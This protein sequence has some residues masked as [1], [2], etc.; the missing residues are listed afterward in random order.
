MKN[1]SSILKVSA[2]ALFAM[3]MSVFA[4]ANATVIVDHSNGGVVDGNG[5][6]NMGGSNWT[7]WD[8]FTL[9]SGATINAIT[10]YAYNTWQSNSPY[11]LQIGTA[12]GLSDV[13]STAIAGSNVTKTLSGYTAKY[14]ASFAPVTLD[15]GTYWITFN[16]QDNLYGSAYAADG[17]LVQMGYGYVE[18]RNGNASVF[19]LSGTTN[20]V[21]E[22]GS[23]ALL[24]IGLGLGALTLRRRK[25]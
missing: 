22:P 17:N 1:F 13:F 16:S 4:P 21:P 5:W 8:D 23:L 2:V 3:S 14:E 15:A 10:Y 25:N 19:S 7:V 18:T 9:T 6:T 11:N 20:D 24:S 12:A